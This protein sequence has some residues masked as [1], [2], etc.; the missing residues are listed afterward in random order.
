VSL[1]L[2]IVTI[3]KSNYVQYFSNYGFNIDSGLNPAV[4][5]IAITIILLLFVFNFFNLKANVSKINKSLI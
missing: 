4:F 1:S 3:I 5:I 2:L